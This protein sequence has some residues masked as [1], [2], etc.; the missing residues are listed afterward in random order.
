MQNI[1]AQ[2]EKSFLISCPNKSI[3]G[4][5]CFWHPAKLIRKLNTGNLVSVGYTDEFEIRLLKYGKGKNNK[6]V[7]MREKTIDGS[8]LNDIFTIPES[9]LPDRIIIEEP[10]P[11]IPN[12]EVPNEL[13]N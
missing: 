5:W 8:E 6:R 11:F 1:K 13:K 4:G 7:V 12:V 2:T 9:Y 10:E 3:Y